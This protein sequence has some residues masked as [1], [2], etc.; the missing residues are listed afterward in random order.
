MCVQ[1][2]H[3][4]LNFETERGYINMEFKRLSMFILGTSLLFG[5]TAYGEGCNVRVGVEPRVGYHCR[6]YYDYHRHAYRRVCSDRLAINDTDPTE[7]RYLTAKQMTVEDFAADYNLQY[8]AAF[9]VLDALRSAEKGNRSKLV[10]IGLSKKAMSDIR[11]GRLPTEEVL[12]NLASNL[13][14]DTATVENAVT[15]LMELNNIKK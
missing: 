4:N 8:D 10:A 2:V 5:L 15:H 12:S 13:G 7:V 11:H 3:T 6:T 9:K 1:E 14:T